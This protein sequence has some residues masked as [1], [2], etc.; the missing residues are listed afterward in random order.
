MRVTILGCWGPYPRAGENC[1]GYLL[2]EGD[3]SIMLD[4]G[5]GTFSCLSELMDFRKLTAVII[6]HFH[7]DHSA[8]IPCLRHAI[9]G[10]NADGT[11]S[12]RLPLYAPEK[13]EEDYARL[14]AQ[15]DAFVI[16]GVEQLPVQ[17]GT[18][19]HKLQVKDFAITFLPTVHPLPCYACRITATG[20]TV[21][22]TA[23][24]SWFDELVPFAQ[25][26]DLLIA[27]CSGFD[28]DRD[29]LAGVHLSARQA[30]NLAKAANVKGLVLTHFWPEFDVNRLV[31]EAAEVYDNVS[32]A[33][34][35][36]VI[37]L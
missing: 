35:K 3:T 2:Q 32:A 8:D 31:A 15:E 13:P 30:A 4:A 22:Y 1:S 29:K 18:G 10:A 25:D 23:D 9:K 36:R 19:Y 7:P 6:S 26:A 16:T 28:K 14:R 33:A 21:V 37:D 34:G 24:T 11:R 12:G 5:H 17:S 27:E 20:K